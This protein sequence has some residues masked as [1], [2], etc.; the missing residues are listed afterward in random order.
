MHPVYCG[1]VTRGIAGRKRNVQFRL[2]IAPCPVPQ[3]ATG[4]SRARCTAGRAMKRS[5]QPGTFFSA[6]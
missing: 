6:S 4:T 2:N 3:P 5:I 1:F